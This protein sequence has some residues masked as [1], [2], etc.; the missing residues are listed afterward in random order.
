MK[1]ARVKM[2]AAER[3]TLSKATKR[4]K[5][6]YSHLTWKECWRLARV[7]RVAMPGAKP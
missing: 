5:R 7:W 4:T 3:E 6:R 1:V 2:S